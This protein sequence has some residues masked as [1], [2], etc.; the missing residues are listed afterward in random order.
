[1]GAEA[2]LEKR[3]AEVTHSL[4]RVMRSPHQH[5]RPAV[6]ALT[7]Y[8]RLT[9]AA[10]TQ[11]RAKQEEREVEEAIREIHAKKERDVAAQVAYRRGLLFGLDK[12]AMRPCEGRCSSDG[13]LAMCRRQACARRN[14]PC[15]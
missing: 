2:W 15:A 8:H 13:V 4:I 3:R 1:M 9:H 11:D 7:S 12:R 5:C 10:R 6:L 14:S